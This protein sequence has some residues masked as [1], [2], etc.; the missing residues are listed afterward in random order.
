MLDRQERVGQP[1]YYE[2]RCRNRAQKW[3]SRAGRNDSS[4]VLQQCTEV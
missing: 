2:G 4:L 1:V 3:V